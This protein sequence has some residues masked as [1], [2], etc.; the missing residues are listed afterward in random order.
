MSSRVKYGTGLVAAALGGA[1]AAQTDP[2]LDILRAFSDL[3]DRHGLPVAIAAVSVVGSLWLIGYLLNH[4]FERHEA[5]VNRLA[6]LR[7]QLWSQYLSEKP[8]SLPPVSKAETKPRKATATQKG[9]R[10]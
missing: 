4:I 3:I 2:F 6:D 7:D 1:A 9:T 8:S 5:E 10:R